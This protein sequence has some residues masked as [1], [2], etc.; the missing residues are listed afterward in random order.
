MSSAVEVL[1]LKVVYYGI[2]T[3]K[4]LKK[5]KDYAIKDFGKENVFVSVDGRGQYSVLVRK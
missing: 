1:V 5:F 3:K 4:D 2:I